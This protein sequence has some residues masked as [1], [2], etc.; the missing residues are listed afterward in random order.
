MPRLE[1]IYGRIMIAAYGQS[2]VPAH[3]N[4]VF[5]LQSLLMPTPGTL[6]GSALPTIY[7]HHL[8]THQTVVAPS[9]RRD[10]IPDDARDIDLV[11]QA[12]VTL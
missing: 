5:K 3:K 12:P 1:N 7:E 2:A 11:M 6:A 10:M 4:T 8:L 9:Q